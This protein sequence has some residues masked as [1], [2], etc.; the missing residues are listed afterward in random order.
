M[1]TD[2]IINTTT[3]GDIFKVDLSKQSIF[4]LCHIIVND[5]TLN[6][7][8]ISYS[9]SI[10]AMDIVDFSKEEGDAFNG[11]NNEDYVLNTML[12]V[13]TRAYEM[14]RRGDLHTDLFQ[15]DGTPTCEPF[16]DRF[17]NVVAG[18]TM[19]LTINVPNGMSIC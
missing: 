13:L 2:P 1:D 8:V 6:E 9:I 5:A 15:V 4:P 3:K 14:L 10:I 17:E 16:T 7:N 12:Q 11:N 19:N 18:W